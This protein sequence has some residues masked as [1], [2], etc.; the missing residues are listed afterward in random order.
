[1]FLDPHGNDGLPGTEDDNLRLSPGSLCIDAGDNTAVPADSADLDGDLDT[2]ERTPLDL[3][4]NP[5]FVDDLDTVDTG[6]DDLPTYPEVVDM[7]AYE[8]PAVLESP[9]L[10]PP[11]HDIL[12]NRY[13]SINPRVTDGGNVGRDLDIR[14]ILSST[15]VNGVTAIGSEWWAH[16]PDGDCIAVVGPTRP[17]TPPNWDACPTLHLT[18][19]PIIPTTQF[20]IVTVDDAVVSDPPLIGQTQAKPGAKWYGD[21]VGFFD[22]STDTWTPPQ[23]MV[24]IDDPVAAIKTFQNPTAFNATHVSVTDVHPNLSGT[25]INKVVNFDDVFVLVL[26]FQGFEIPGPD[27]ELCPD[28]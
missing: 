21:A 20:D 25:Q 12:K 4:G 23:G 17:V 24:N 14:L 9:T 6:V 22:G 1:M 19:C 2:S 27:I 15:Q 7:G 28:P 8:A 11:P 26:G 10:A 18:G 13:I 5:R 3:D 16:G